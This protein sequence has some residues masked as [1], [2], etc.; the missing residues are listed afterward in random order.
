MECTHTNTILYVGFTEDPLA[1][2]GQHHFPVEA[3]HDQTRLNEYEDRAV[4]YAEEQRLIKLHQ[5]PFN[6]AS[7]GTYGYAPST[8]PN[9]SIKTLERERKRRLWLT[10]RLK[11]WDE[12]NEPHPLPTHLLR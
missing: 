5:P 11:Y 7:K 8:V 4:A 6:T 1:R 3:C 12:K 9:Y 2:P 10:N